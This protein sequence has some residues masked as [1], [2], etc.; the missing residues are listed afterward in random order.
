M[1]YTHSLIVVLGQPVGKFPIWFC[2]ITKLHT[3]VCTVTGNI[4]GGSISVICHSSVKTDY[5]PVT[6]LNYMWPIILLLLTVCS[7]RF[8]LYVPI[9][10]LPIFEQNC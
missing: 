6:F 10:L 2:P 8:E 4:G 3:Y 1:C 5:F 9:L 7:A